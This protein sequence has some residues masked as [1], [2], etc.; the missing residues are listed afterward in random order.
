MNTITD[1]IFCKIIKKEIPAY[2]VFENDDVMAFLD[3]NPVRPGHTLIVPKKHIDSFTHMS[4]DAYGNLMK[5][6]HVVAQQIEKKIDPKRVGLII[7]GF[8]VAHVHVH[9]V[10]LQSPSDISM[11]SARDELQPHSLEEIAATLK[12]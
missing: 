12:I 5:Y 9:L 8:D 2:I 1:C 4:I 11:D 7:E 3:N 10:P 6:A